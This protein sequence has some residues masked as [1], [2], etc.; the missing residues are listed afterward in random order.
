M[1]KIWESCICSV[2]ALGLLGFLPAEAKIGEDIRAYKTRIL[3]TAK[4]IQEVKNPDGS[5]H[6]YF[7]VSIAPAQKEAS[8]GYAVAIDIASKD[9][10]IVA[11]EMVIRPG[12]GGSLG[13]ALAC[14]QGIAFMY[15]GIGYAPPN[16]RPAVEAEFKAFTE[17]VHGGLLGKQQFI[18]YPRNKNLTGIRSDNDGNIRIGIA[19]APEYQQ[20]SNPLPAPNLAQP[21][22]AK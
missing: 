12:T 5:M 16:S 11:Q 10:K 14:A 3:K 6:S 8:N 7:D 22:Q 2:F 17:A 15:E 19:V 4:L 20:V 1:R 9:N 21:G 13:I 18:R